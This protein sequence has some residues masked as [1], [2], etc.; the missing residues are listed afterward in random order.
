MAK[1]TV[2]RE[3][4]GRTPQRKGGRRRAA[5]CAALLLAFTGPPVAAQGNF[6]SPAVARGA[7]QD[8]TA[9]LNRALQSGNAQ[10]L[11]KA[12]ADAQSVIASLDTLGQLGQYQKELAP[13]LA[14]YFGALGQVLSLGVKSC[15]GGSLSDGFATAHLIT[16]LSEAAKKKINNLSTYESKLASCL[17]L[18]LKIDSMVKNAGLRYVAH[19]DIT[20]KLNYSLKDNTYSGTGNIQKVIQKFEDP[21]GGCSVKLTFT[22]AQFTVK[23]MALSL[24][25]NFRPKD[26][27]LQDY[28]AGET[29]E[30]ATISCPK[31]GTQTIPFMNWGVVYSGIHEAHQ[32]YSVEQW[33]TGSAPLLLRKHLD[34]SFG[35]GEAM[36]S[37]STDYVLTK[38]R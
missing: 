30:A 33:Q 29:N 12:I 19:V 13:L 35:E 22:P 16:S 24:D 7:I 31:V 37:E 25:Q 23:R 6:G 17:G 5:L 38:T 2:G 11:S 20:V 32:N 36:L 34:Q 18:T 28:T 4:T 15:E 14:A 9:E 8:V 27:I 21:Y 1:K 3:A 10:A 26:A